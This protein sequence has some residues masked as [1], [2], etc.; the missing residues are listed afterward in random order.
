MSLIESDVVD[1]AQLITASGRID[2]NTAE[3]FQREL[4][5]QVENAAAQNF[6]V[7]LDLSAVPYMSS[8]GLRGLMLAYKKCQSAGTRIVAFG[9]NDVMTEIFQISRFDKIFRILT[10]RNDALAA[11]KK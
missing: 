3:P 5:E 8:A 2:F 1:G 10:S 9:L 7:I 11:V 6:P 4:L